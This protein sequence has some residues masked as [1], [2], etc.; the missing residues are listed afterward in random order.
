ME[1]AFA[2]LNEIFSKILRLVPRIRIIRS[3]HAGVAFVRGKPRLIPS[4]CLCFY[5]PLWT[6][7]ELI[8]IRRQ[9]LNLANQSLVTC[10][11]PPIE[12]TCSGIVVYEI[13]DPLIAI[14]SVRELDCAI[15]DLALA[16]I[17]RSLYGQ[18][19]DCITAGTQLNGLELAMTKSLGETL[20]EFGIRVINV[21]LS[22]LSTCRV[23]RHVGDSASYQAISSIESDE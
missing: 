3:T 22:D 19:Y 16:E 11:D 10:D 21:F 17:R 5:W 7:I 2:W 6:E 23:F 20:D 12:I 4:G 9:T 14:T 15:A 13:S 8:P 18:P 1:Q